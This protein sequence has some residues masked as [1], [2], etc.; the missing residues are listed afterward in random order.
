MCVIRL[1]L[2]SASLKNFFIIIQLIFTLMMIIRFKWQPF[3]G[4]NS[5]RKHIAQNKKLVTKM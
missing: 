1:S 3:Q 5:A 4:Y 2:H